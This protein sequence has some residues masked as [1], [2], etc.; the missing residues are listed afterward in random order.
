MRNSYGKEF[1]INGDLLVP[2][3]T[4]TYNTEN[5]ITIFDAEL[6]W[7][8]LSNNLKIKPKSFFNKELI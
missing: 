3:G 8:Y 1:G 6:M 2:R 5:H 7:N 4:N